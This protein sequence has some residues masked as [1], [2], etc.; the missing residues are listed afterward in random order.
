MIIDLQSERERAAPLFDMK[1]TELE[2]TLMLMIFSKIFTFHTLK[3]SCLLLRFAQVLELDRE[4][5]C[6]RSKLKIYISLEII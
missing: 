2:I 4:K 6:H 5:P 1:I 3:I